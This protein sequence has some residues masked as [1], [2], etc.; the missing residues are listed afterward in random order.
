MAPVRLL[1]LFTVA[2]TSALVDTHQTSTSDANHPT[3]QTQTNGPARQPNIVFVLADDLGYNDVGWHNPWI[4]TPHLDKLAVTGVRLENY[5]VQPICTPTRSQLLSGR[6]QIHTG[7]Q[8]GIIWWAQANA[9]PRQTPTIADVLRTS[10]YRTHMVGKWH[11]GFYKPEYMPINRGF[12]S[13]FGFLTGSEDHLTH[14]TC[15]K[16]WCGYDLRDGLDPATNMEGNYST[17]MYTQKAVDL[18]NNHDASKPL[19]LYLAY[20]AT[21]EPLQVPDSY[22]QQYPD[23]EDSNRRVF[24]GM[25]TCLDE[26]VRNVTTALQN[27]GM[28]DNTVVIFS[29]DNGGQ[30][31]FSGNNWPL[32]GWKGSLWEGGMRASGFVHSPLLPTHVQGTKTR[33]LMHVTDWFPTMQTLAGSHPLAGLDGFDQWN[34]I[35]KGAQSPRKELLHN[36]DPLAEPKGQQLYN[37]TFDTRVQAAIRVG[38]YKLLTGDP[39]NGSWV[40]AP[41]SGWPDRVPNEAGGKNVWLFNV[42]TDPSEWHDLSDQRPDIVRQLLDR[43]NYYNSTAEPC[44]YPSDD[45]RADP[46][47]HGGFWG[48]WET[49]ATL[50]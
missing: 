28:W 50:V 8:H 49:D 18:I 12:D 33:E 39:G 4:Q 23:I 20:Q 31:Y 45:P 47:L 41:E 3:A 27:K 22:L 40:A 36:I 6:Y 26:G 14:I 24:A 46:Q 15:Y 21:H 38:D 48:P 16:K 35:S 2:L 11:L 25:A 44:R 29:A 34:T 17:T 7:L 5:Y 1:V 43:L 9:L 19:F 37:D 42:R 13:Y 30:V 32:R 10:G